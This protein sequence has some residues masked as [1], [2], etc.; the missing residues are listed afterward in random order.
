MRRQFILSLALL[1]LGLPRRARPVS[2][3]VLAP[4]PISEAQAAFLQ[5]DYGRAA[6]LYSQALRQNPNDP[7]LVAGSLEVLLKQQRIP[8]A[9]DLISKAIGSN[10]QSVILQTALGLVQYRE[11]KPWLTAKTS[12]AALSLDPCYP[13]LHLLN[14]YLRRLNSMYKDADTELRTAHLLDPS[15]QAIRRYWLRTLPLKSRIAEVEGYL[16]SPTGADPDELRHMRL[17][18][19]RL[20]KIASQP[21][22]ACQLASNEVT[23]DIRFAPIM[24]DATRIR[25]FG[26][27]VKL[28]N[29][30]ARLQIDTGA[31]GL[32]VSRSVAQSLS[33]PVWRSSRRA[34]FAA[35]AAATR[36]PLIPL[37]WTRSRSVRWSFGIAR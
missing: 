18:L 25:A 23:T 3:P 34:K 11:G 26:L 1:A 17:Y 24:R 36:N 32:L 37:L 19:N 22:K 21:H 14:M 20:R 28:N 4:R 8:E 33:R 2:C 15:D 29:H 12:E 16:A 30:N 10:P 27:D 9:D 31:S 35:S 6:G 5:S 7:E 13:R